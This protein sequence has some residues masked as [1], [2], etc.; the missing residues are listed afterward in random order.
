[1]TFTDT[2]VDGSSNPVTCGT[3]TFN[4]GA[5]PIGGCSAVPLGSPSSNEA[6]CSTSSLAVGNNNITAVY[7]SGGGSCLYITSTSNTVVQAVNAPLKV[8]PYSASFPNSTYANSGTTVP[9]N[10][11]LTALNQSAVPITIGTITT[12]TTG[13]PN[14]GPNFATTSDMC[15]GVTLAPSGMTGDSCTFSLT[16][17]ATALGTFTG[18][19]S[20]PSNA[21]NSPNVVTLSGTGVAPMINL[22]PAITFPATQVGTTSSTAG[23]ATLTNP[24]SVALTVSSIG[25]SGNFSIAPIGSNPC[26]LMGSTILAPSGMAGSSCTVGV[27][28]TPTMVGTNTGSLSVVSNASN[29]PAAIALKGTGTLAALTLSPTSVKFGVVPSGTTSPDMVVTVTNPNTA[30]GGTVSIT[31]IGTSNSVFGI[32]S[33]TCGSTLPPSG[34]C[35]INVNFSPTAA[36]SYSGTLNIDDNAG[37]GVQ[38][39]T[40]YGTGS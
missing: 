36:G 16:F 19:A 18:T 30:V 26:N 23:T 1:V 7:N 8:T 38:K 35:T 14:G 11:F 2:V 31:G 32:D 39:G 21:P 15:S 20:V 27:N 40:L 33:T 5:T 6:Q 9:Y 13:G 12:A 37:T 24:N 4:N 25:V 34:M 10:G 29:S 22:S 3:V 28:F 17:T